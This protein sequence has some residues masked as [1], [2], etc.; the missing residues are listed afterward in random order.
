[1]GHLTEIA[2]H[3]TAGNV[4]PE[5]HPQRGHLPAIGNG[6]EN[7]ANRDDGDRLIR[8]FDSNGRFTGNR[9]LDANARCRQCQ[10]QI[11]GER[12]DTR[13]LYAALGFELVSSDR[14]PALDVR[15][16]R[17]DSEA[18]KRIFE[19]VRAIRLVDHLP[20]RYVEERKIGKPI[21]RPLLWH[22]EPLDCARDR[23]RRRMTRDRT[24]NR[25]FTLSDDA[26]ERLFEPHAAARSFRPVRSAA[27]ARR[28]LR[29]ANRGRAAPAR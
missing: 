14:R 18:R 22:P 23:L 7:L 19:E 5:R 27:R 25:R 20:R 4:F 9:R 28:M 8:H 11:V 2:D 17:A 15:N 29:A 13:N 21:G 26:L 12:R 6:V 3:R 24:L 1:M 16:L 10:R